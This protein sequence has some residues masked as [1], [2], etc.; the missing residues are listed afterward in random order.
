MGIAILCGCE[1]I[2]SHLGYVTRSLHVGIFFRGL[3]LVSILNYYWNV[4]KSYHCV[5]RYVENHDTPHK[6]AEKNSKIRLS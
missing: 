2:E 5:D 3:Q 1:V 4:A 6:R